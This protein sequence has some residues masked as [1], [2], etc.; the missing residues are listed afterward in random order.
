MPSPSLPFV[1]FT[2]PGFQFGLRRPLE[3]REEIIRKHPQPC[4]I[5][6]ISDIH[7]RRGRSQ[8]LASQIIDAAQRARPAI[9]LLGGDL[10][11]QASE[12]AGLGELLTRLLELAPVLAV[13]GNHDLAVGEESV[14][15]TVVAAGADWL[16][17]RTVLV[18][19]RERVI[20]ISG[21]G[22]K[23]APEA[24]AR[25]LCAHDPRIWKVARNA[26]FELVLAGHLHGCQGVLF[27]AGGRLFPGA[28]FYPH[29][30]L[31]QAHAGSRLVVSRGCSDLLP[32]RWGCPREILLCIL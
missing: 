17:A 9:I 25:V 6:Y 8:L 31:R 13:P 10:V 26:G 30:H 24:D 3:V 32:V 16:A 21:P 29:N 4:R 1:R 12:L 18:R 15:Q 7:L 27:E 2:K 5:A 23:P 11:D 19:H 28:V 20:A 14:R 22:A